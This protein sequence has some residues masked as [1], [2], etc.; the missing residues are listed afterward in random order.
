VQEATAG[1]RLWDKLRRV[2]WVGK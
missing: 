2:G 1:S